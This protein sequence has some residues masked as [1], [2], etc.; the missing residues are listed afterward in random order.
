MKE[1]IKEILTGL[2]I[3]DVDSIV[4]TL[5]KEIALLTVPKD[6]YNSLS[7]RVKSIESEKATVQEELD[8]LKEKSM[9]DEQKQAKVQE[10][11]E[12]KTKELSIEINKMKA[13]NIFQNANIEESKI[14]DL[15]EKVVSDDE[16][17][18][19]ELA[20]SFAEILKVEV[21]KTKTKTESDLMLNTPKPSIKNDSAG[22][23][24]LTKEDFL[25]MSYSEKKELFLTNPE[26]YNEFIK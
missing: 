3:D 20:N 17:K 22:K 8:N 14:D 10:N 11:Y 5:A 15:L 7:D 23:K 19:L 18:T 24:E 6:K 1:K 12:K 26:Q 4:D 13:R 2:N 16:T 21:D 25:K 9:T